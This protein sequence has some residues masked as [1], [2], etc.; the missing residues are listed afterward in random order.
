[1]TWN[2]RAAYF[3]YVLND[4]FNSTTTKAQSLVYNTVTLEKRDFETS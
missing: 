2:V 4:F 3:H 1:M